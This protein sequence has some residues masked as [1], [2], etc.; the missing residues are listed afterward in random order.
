[1]SF[2]L[3][4]RIFT[5]IFY[6]AAAYLLPMIKGIMISQIVSIIAPTALWIASIHVDMP[7]RLGFIIPA[8]F[9]DMYG[10]IAFFTLLRYKQNHNSNVKWKQW[11]ERMFE[12]I[13]AI[14]IEH[15]VERMNAFVSLVFGYSVVAILFQNQG[16]YDINAFLGKAILGLMQAFTFNWIYFDIDSRNIK[17]HAIR[18]SGISGQSYSY[19]FLSLYFIANTAIA[20][21][22]GF[23]HLP[24]V[25]GY[26][27]ATSALSRL[28]LATDV[29]GTNLNQLAEPYRDS[30][31]DEFNSGVRFFY[32]HGLAIALLCMAVISFSHEHKK[33]PTL[34]LNKNIR[35]A[36]RIAVC[37][38]MFFLPLA[39]SLHSLSLISITLSLTVWALIVE[40]WGKSCTDDPFI[41]EKDG[42]CITYCARCKKDDV[43][44]M[45]A[46]DEKP[47]RGELLELD[48]AEKTA[49]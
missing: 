37:V 47:L 10:H 32:C 43:E 30:A 19:L 24:F 46:S 34:R 29:P 11:F 23:S 31:E 45:I 49:V 22:W 41:G 42:C 15:R 35:L 17:L 8:L 39:T 7:R 27:V 2:Y 38:I 13:P 28:V 36:N 18:R 12:F 4:A 1:M 16:G 14:S 33:Q 5:A 20:G 3:A 48:R 44:E 21:L 40:L 25:M 9:L 6:G 26:I